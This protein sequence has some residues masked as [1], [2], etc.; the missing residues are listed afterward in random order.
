MVREFVRLP[1]FERQCK[2]IGLAEDD[3]K[4]IESA[5]LTNPHVGNVLK[6]TG[7]IH[8]FRFALDNRG[9][10]SGARVVYIDFA[11]FERIYLLTAFAK[12]EMGNLS[13]AERNELRALVQMLKSEL[14]K[15]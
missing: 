14:E 2:S 10:S 9:K 1:E 11:V 15:R 8:K 3:V 7:G 13:P 12:S 6:G 5:L 4:E